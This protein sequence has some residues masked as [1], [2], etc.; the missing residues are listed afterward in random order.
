MRD[1]A[2]T[3]IGGLVVGSVYALIALGMSLIYSMSKVINLS[4]GAFVVLAA[5]TGV[6]VQHSLHI[7]GPALL[8]VVAVIFAVV[9]AVVD[10]AVIRPASRRASPDRM[11]LITVGLL[12]A[13]GGLLLL[14][15]GNLPYT[16]KPFTHTAVVTVLGLRLSTQ[17]FWVL[18]VLAL[19]L[20]ALWLLLQR[21]SLGLKMRATA[22]DPQAASLMG[23]D[24]DKVR[25]IAFSISG[26]LAAVAGVAIIPLTFLQYDT[27]VP[28][29]VDGFV[30]AV[31]G[32]LGSSSGAVMGGL[33]LGVV[34]GVLQRYTN[35]SLAEILAISSLI[36][37]LLLRPAGLRGTLA[38]VRR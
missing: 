10:L 9:L 28:Y 6:S 17:F 19:S 22:Q 8:V 29:A 20:V 12:Q 16:M 13:V 4:Q 11:L 33:L 24:V 26:A 36:L 1:V 31:L 34:Q 30:A 15:W 3:V 23:V 18:G 32:G 25:L 21:S 37:I 38:E 5:L 27:V 14:R 7:S 2:E 35:A